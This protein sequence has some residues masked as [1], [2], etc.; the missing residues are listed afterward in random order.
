MLERRNNTG[1]TFCFF[2]LVIGIELFGDNIRRK[3]QLCIGW[4][5]KYEQTK[6]NDIMSMKK[7]SIWLAVIGGLLFAS[8]EKKE[9]VSEGTLPTVATQFISTH[10]PDENVL[11]VKKEKDF[12]GKSIFEVL[13]SNNYELEFKESGEAQK[14]D[15][16]GKQIPEAVISP[17]TILTYLETEFPDF[18][19]IAWEKDSNGEVEVEL[20]NGLELRFNKE[21]EFLRFDD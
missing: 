10:F 17:T 20:N 4:N 6:F 13:L 8:C 18:Y 2:R 7:M 14:V 3:I 16:N 12:I 19:A 9:I 15:G 11:Q 21:G 5:V 1:Q